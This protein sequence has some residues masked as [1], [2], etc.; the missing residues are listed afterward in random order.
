[1]TN[2]LASAFGFAIMTVILIAVLGAVK[3]TEKFWF[4]AGILLLVSGPLLV[5]FL[6]LSNGVGGGVSVIGLAAILGS[7]VPLLRQSPTT[8]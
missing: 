4:A 7:V 2:H 3:R 6:A 8:A 1:M 5:E